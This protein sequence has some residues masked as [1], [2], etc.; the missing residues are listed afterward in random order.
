MRKIGIIGAGPA[1]VFAA[2]N[3]KNENNQV[4]LLD[5]NNQIGE[6]LKITGNGRCN[7]TNAKYYDEF[8]EN[9]IRNKNFLYSAFS[10]F[11]NFSMIDFLNKEGIET[12]IEEDGKVFPKS[13]RSSEIICLFERLIR[14]KGIRFIPKT[15][16][17]NIEK[18]DC[19]LLETSRGKY[20]FDSLIIATGG[21]TYLKTGSTGDGYTFARSFGHKIINTK[22]SL[23]PL[24]LEDRI[25]VKALSLSDKKLCLKTMEKTY[26]IRG[27]IM[28]TPNFI[29]GPAAI[30]IQA[31]AARDH[32]KILSIDFLPEYTYEMLDK[33]LISIFEDN[34]RKN[35]SN[36]LNLL[37]NDQLVSI[38]LD[39]LKINKDMK[40]SEVS[41]EDRKSIL[42]S[43]KAFDLKMS[44]KENFDNAV[45]TSGGVDLK[46]INPKTMESKLV[47]DLY[48]I[49]EVLD[50]DA[51]T[52]GFNLQ[53][54]FTTAYAASLDIKEKI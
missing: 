5:K 30:K 24:Y 42:D 29:T 33:K 54:A 40:V 8:L 36:V 14:E 39:R 37:L 51:L 21:R 43:I 35:L 12:V 7:V 3:I 50:I 15:E 27:D 45:I 16:V 38:L 9:I 47:K 17:E 4:Y 49:G 46:E 13:S 1:G 31:L 53:I 19:F 26:E 23:M 25:N 20:E 2:I 44:Q 34:S 41:R 6:K 52:G 18:S 48:F 22:A 10:R 28:L 32:L 11:D